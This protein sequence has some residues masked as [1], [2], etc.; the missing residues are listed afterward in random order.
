MRFFARI[1][2]GLSR[3]PVVGRVVTRIS[4][5]REAL[6]LGRQ[7]QSE[8]A[9]ASLRAGEARREAERAGEAAAAREARTPIQRALDEIREAPFRRVVLGNDEVATQVNERMRY[10]TEE[11]GRAAYHDL[12]DAG[13]PA[14]ILALVYDP[15]TGMWV[16][17]VGETQ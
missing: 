15:L 16:L 10:G 3:I 8:R 4:S 12:I 6:D 9:A 2:A 1:R 7:I 17:Y 14:F 13:V 11:S 5:R